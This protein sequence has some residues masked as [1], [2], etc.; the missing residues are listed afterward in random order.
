MADQTANEVTD[1]AKAAVA[2]APAKAP[3]AETVAE[4]KAEAAPAKV[5]PA[6]APV[7]KALVAM[8][9]IAAMGGVAA[10]L[11]LGGRWKRNPDALKQLNRSC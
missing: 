7:A 5:E 9:I 11:G 10:Y 8:A 1:T 6:K 4:P 2:Q 3:A